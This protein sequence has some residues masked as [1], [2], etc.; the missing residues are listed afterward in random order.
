MPEI[1]RIFDSPYMQEQLKDLS[2]SDIEPARITPAASFSDA[3]RCSESVELE[4]L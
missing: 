3:S 4:D 1:Q 2:I